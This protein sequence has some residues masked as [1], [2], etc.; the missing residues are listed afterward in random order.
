MPSIF[1]SWSGS[2]PSPTV[3]AFLAFLFSTEGRALLN[4]AGYLPTVPAD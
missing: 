2:E 3:E 1:T 4:E